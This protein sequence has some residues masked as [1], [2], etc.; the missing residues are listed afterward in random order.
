MIK[1]E[2]ESE[3]ISA[4]IL[5]RNIGYDK[6]NMPEFPGDVFEKVSEDEK[7]VTRIYIYRDGSMSKAFYETD[8]AEEIW[9]ASGSILYEEFLAIQQLHREMR[10]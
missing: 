6:I 7:V 8:N 10:L 1:K 5:F 2:I 3:I 4:E 9:E